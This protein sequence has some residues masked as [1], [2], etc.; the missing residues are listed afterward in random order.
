M[1]QHSQPSRTHSVLVLIV[2]CA[3]VA[4]CKGS[5]PPPPRSTTQEAAP[6]PAPA[7]AP[8]TKRPQTLAEKQEWANAHPWGVHTGTS[9]LHGRVEWPDAP[10][11]VSRRRLQLKG[12]KG[13]PNDGFVYMVYADERGEYDFDRIKGGVF[14]LSDDLRTPYHWRLRVE[15]GE[16]EDR[17]IDL[18]PGNSIKAQDD[19]QEDGK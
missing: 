8:A 4:G 16:G 13:T 2:L 15:I 11:E 6:A 17:V 18:N 19:F 12:L 9:R 7:S 3:T 14:K 10:D 5:P 1:L